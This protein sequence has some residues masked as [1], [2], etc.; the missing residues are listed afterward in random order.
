MRVVQLGYSSGKECLEQA[1]YGAPSVTFGF[2]NQ[3]RKWLI[4]AQLFVCQPPDNFLWEQPSAPYSQLTLAVSTGSLDLF[5]FATEKHAEMFWRDR[6]ANV[7]SRL[8][9][10][11]I[12]TGLRHITEAYNRISIA[13]VTAKLSFNAFDHAEFLITKAI[14]DGSIEA[15]I[16][17]ENGWMCS[18]A[19]QK[20]CST[21]GIKDILHTRIIFCLDLYNALS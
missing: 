20:T 4:L 5:K 19:K 14:Y 1:Y 18:R 8:R 2:R 16:D 3:V 6:T 11:V 9:N 17:H 10:N 7:I 15:N 13:D 21:L 12:R